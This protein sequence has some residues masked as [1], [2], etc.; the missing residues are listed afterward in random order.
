M[1]GEAMT[2]AAV[3]GQAITPITGAALARLPDWRSRLGAYLAGKR[4]SPFVYGEHDCA[5]FAAGAVEA[6][7][8]SDPSAALGIR[9]TTLAGGRHALRARG[10]GNVAPGINGRDG[11]SGGGGGGRTAASTGGAATGGQGHNGGAGWP[12]GSNS[13]RAGGGGGGAGAAGGDAAIRASPK[14]ASRNLTA[15]PF[16]DAPAEP[17]LPNQKSISVRAR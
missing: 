13:N 12:D 1:T 3:A 8:G 11:G 5:R 15:G 16:A 6:V 17:V 2:G 9:Y 7:T 14:V 4:T 10:S